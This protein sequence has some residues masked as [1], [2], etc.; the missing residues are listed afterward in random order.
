M[1]EKRGRSV[2]WWLLLCR[3][4]PFILILSASIQKCNCKIS[5]AAHMWLNC[6]ALNPLRPQ[7]SSTHFYFRI[8]LHSFRIRTIWADDKISI[9]FDFK[10]VFQLIA[11]EF[12]NNWKTP[13]AIGGGVT[14]RGADLHH[15]M[16]TFG[17]IKATL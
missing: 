3:V 12:F 7:H 11:C 5:F 15:T 14:E 16:R 2:G 8:L 13:V 4:M 17:R 6:H 1:W 10:R 9:Q